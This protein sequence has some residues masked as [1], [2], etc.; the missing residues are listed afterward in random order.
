MNIARKLDKIGAALEKLAGHAFECRLCPRECGVNR[1]AGEMGF[2]ESGPAA[3]VSHALLHYGEEPVLSGGHGPGADPAARSGSGTVF[4]SGCS[5]KCC[6]C[7]N[8]QLS[9]LGR[10]RPA[11]DEELAGMMLSL[12]EKGALRP[13]QMILV[14]LAG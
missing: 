4:F 7:Q 6:F 14:D 9:W 13:R 10:G 1:S 2:C 12:Q 3:V 11:G 5:L 8:Y